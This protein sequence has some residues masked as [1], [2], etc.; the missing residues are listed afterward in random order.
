MDTPRLEALIGAAVFVG[1]CCAPAAAHRPYFSQPEAISAEGYSTVE[2][3][4]LHGDGVLF[5]D[6][7]RAVV[8]GQDGELLA[9]SPQSPALQLSCDDEMGQCLVYDELAFTIYEPAA[10]KWQARGLVE[11]DGEAQRFPEDIDADFGFEA[12]RATLSEIVRFEIAGLAS[13]WMTTAFALAWWT[14]FCLLLL[15]VARDAF[16]KTRR[17]T[18]RAIVSLLARTAAPLMMIPLATY[19]WLLAPYSIVYLAVVMAAGAAVALP[20]AFRRREV[21]TR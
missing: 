20:I 7:I 6:P 19:A 3:K 12:R 21:A 16:D 13:S 18:I 9:A 5:A 8:V 15:T 2:L 14:A 17:L 4:L 1:M 11:Q 10:D